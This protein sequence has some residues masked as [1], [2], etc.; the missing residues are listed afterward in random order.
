[1]NA[2]KSVGAVAGGLLLM[3]VIW[4]IAMLFLRGVA[5]VSE[6]LIPWLMTAAGYA[7][8]ICLLVLLPLSFFRKTRVFAMWGLMA[9]SFVFGAFVWVW[10]FLVTYELWGL[11]G[12]V[13][14]LFIFGVGVVPIGIVAAMFHGDWTTA[15]WLLGLVVLTF[16]TRAYALYV[17][18]RADED[19]E[20][21]LYLEL[22]ASE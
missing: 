8:W 16:G 1:M 14:G 22:E 12:L 6:F 17:A 11:F 9:G 13:A 4:T 10:G 5:Y 2:L 3:V 20:A 15:W 19:A 21:R 18:K 7:F